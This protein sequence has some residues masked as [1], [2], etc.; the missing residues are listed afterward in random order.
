M[1]IRRADPARQRADEELA[2]SG[3]RIVD[4]PCLDRP[5]PQHSSTHQTLLG[6]PKSGSFGL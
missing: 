6:T 4:D 2:R 3:H 1:Q 5:A